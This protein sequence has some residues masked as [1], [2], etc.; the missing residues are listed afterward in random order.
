MQEYIFVNEFLIQSCFK[1]YVDSSCHQ[2]R[3]LL[4]VPVRHI[5]IRATNY[6]NYQMPALHI[7][8]LFP[9]LA[10]K[11]SCF[12]KEQVV[13]ST[14]SYSCVRFH[15]I[16]F[17][18][19]IN[20]LGWNWMM[21]KWGLILHEWWRCIWIY[22]SN[23]IYDPPITSGAKSDIM[24]CNNNEPQ[25][26]SFHAFQC[27]VKICYITLANDQDWRVQK[28]MKNQLNWLIL[29]FEPTD[30]LLFSFFFFP[31]THIVVIS[32]LHFSFV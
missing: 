24:S 7:G 28:F 23:S 19:L 11:L 5:F 16:L 15:F 9:L 18:C 1:H 26:T 27:E 25:W 8:T 21:L 22:D 2:K 10:G 4:A 14:T 17:S 6:I 32:Y 3:K 12:E 31:T 20:N 30:V 13:I 29:S